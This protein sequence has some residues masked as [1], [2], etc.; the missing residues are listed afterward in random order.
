[1]SLVQYRVKFCCVPLSTYIVR[2][3]HNPIIVN[4]M[5][6]VKHSDWLLQVI[7]MMPKFRHRAKIFKD[8]VLYVGLM[9][10]EIKL[11]C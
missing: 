3:G 5:L 6:E 9:K 11:A 8:R 1:M 2:L 7:F 10:M 4:S